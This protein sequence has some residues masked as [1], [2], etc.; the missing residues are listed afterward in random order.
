M[1]FPCIL[2]VEVRVVNVNEPVEDLVFPSL[3]STAQFDG[4]DWADCANTITL[5]G[6]TVKELGV[7]GV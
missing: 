6:E 5:S 4:T 2:V 3:S 7:D 1:V